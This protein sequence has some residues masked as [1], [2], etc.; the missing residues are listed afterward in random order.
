MGF[1]GRKKEVLETGAARCAQEWLDVGRERRL[2]GDEA[3]EVSRNQ[4]KELSLWEPVVFPGTHAPRPRKFSKV[5]MLAGRGIPRADQKKD[6][7]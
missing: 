1:P 4:N 5:I 6:M 2:V 3:K 7:K